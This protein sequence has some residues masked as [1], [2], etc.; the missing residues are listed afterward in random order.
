MSHHSYFT[1]AVCFHTQEQFLITHDLSLERP[2]Q[3]SGQGRGKATLYTTRE[4]G[5][6]LYGELQGAK[7]PLWGGNAKGAYLH[8]W[9]TYTLWGVFKPLEYIWSVHTPQLLQTAFSSEKL[10]TANF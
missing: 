9:T 10:C 7:T 2:E 5:V 1:F 6:L 4:V 3:V 8:L